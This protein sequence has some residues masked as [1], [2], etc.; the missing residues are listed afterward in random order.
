MFP[1]HIETESLELRQLSEA[2]VDVFELYE[3]FSDS[4]GDVTEVFEH[5]PQE[6]YATVNETRERLQK[7][8]S[9]WDDGDAAQY[10]IVTADEELA[11]FTGLFLEWER[12]SARIGFILGKPYWGNGYA[13]EC[14]MALTDLAFDRLDLELVAIGHEAGNERSNRA[15]EDDTHSDSL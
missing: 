14:A 4:R 5:V 11:G 7:A 3:L 13:G 12:K 6:P 9:A 2:S 10:A 8:Q 1:E 15:I